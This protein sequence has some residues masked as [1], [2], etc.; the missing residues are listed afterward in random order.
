MRHVLTRLVVGAGLGLS[1]L[2]GPVSA[3]SVGDS[4]ANP[5]APGGANARSN[6]LITPLGST[7]TQ[8]ASGLGGWLGGGTQ[9]PNRA[10]VLSSSRVSVTA[11][12]L[13]L[14]ENGQ[15]IRRLAVRPVSDAKGQDFG[16]VLALDRNVSMKGASLASALVAA[17]TLVA[18]RTGAPQIG[19]ISF[20]SNATVTTPMTSNGRALVETLQSAPRVGAGSNVPAAIE[21]A[22]TQLA[23]AR[24]AAGAVIL[25]SDGANTQAPAAA[26]SA[27]R[28][29]AMSAHIPIV[30]VALR[31]G[32]SSS[33]GIDLL[34]ASAT[35]AALTADPS[36]LAKSVVAAYTRLTQGAYVVRYRSNA[37]AGRQVSVDA[38]LSGV[39]APL[40][41]AYYTPGTP[42]TAGQSP[43]TT[44]SNP[45]APVST[46]TTAA[47][48][49]TSSQA[50]GSGS[51][52]AAH[53]GA[54]L[55]G[56]KQGSKPAA[57]SGKGPV[58]SLP[59]TIV[60]AP[61]QLL[62]L[63]P[64]SYF[65]PAVAAQNASAVSGSF[66]SSPLAIFLVATV[67]G[68][69]LAAG[70]WIALGGPKA[71][72]GVRA[73]V[74]SFIPGSAAGDAQLVAE[75]NR[76][77]GLE[78]FLVRR[79]W[80]AAF[81]L[82]IQVARITRG[83]VELIKRWAVGALIL[84]AIVCVALSTVLPA[85]LIM[86][87][88][89]TAMRM[90]V[91]RAARKQRTRFREQLPS[92]L[93]DLAG[94]MRAGRS[95]VGGLA[96][97]ASGSEE[98]MRS[99]LDRVV[100]DEQLGRP[101]EQSLDAVAARMESEDM[102][103]VA[104]VAGLSRRSGSNIAESLDRVAEGA[105]ERLDMRREIQ[106]LTGQ[107]RMS[108]WVLS[109]LPVF[110]LLGISLLAPSYSQPLFHTTTGIVLLVVGAGMVLLGR[111]IMSRITSVKM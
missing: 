108:G 104:L 76:P 47:P 63:A 33:G 31:D 95:L 57:S 109:G 93:Q 4:I 24:V 41:L 88:W 64:P 9:F 1:M 87:A 12:R 28:A 19:V 69:L 61:P 97:V 45:A 60:S 83:P 55:T 18:Q 82:N 54:R 78:S 30:T 79:R 107:A 11:A 67:C 29:G 110:L 71:R 99:E 73:R 35:N 80:W 92:H 17:R 37:S 65:G 66:W 38:R 43:A 50:S 105:R 91:R 42:S 85:L 56:G 100:A 89:P 101:L 59:G 20:D 53:G 26:L 8:S 27:A 14:T 10:L 40:Q 16:L 15:T 48:G 46:P 103:Q 58:I 23:D 84:S 106:A 74:R 52:S 86:A 62:T 96:A 13:R 102:E 34:R 111:Q 21:L 6:V 70:L 25:I 7:V 68:L 75:Q 49:K 44:T 51:G 36:D 2:A 81:I 39:S 72:R 22:L 32:A 90:Q 5:V 98:P 94:A 3:V 77:R